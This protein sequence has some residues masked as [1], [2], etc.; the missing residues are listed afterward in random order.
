ML[1]RQS[2]L[3][4]TQQQVATGKRILSPSDDVYGSTQILALNK[5][6]DTHVQYEENADV[7]EARLNQEEISLTQNINVLQRA[8]ELAVQASN[9]TLSAADRGLIAAEVRDC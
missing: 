6:I 3:S 2:E 1:D 4:K 7:V 8:K 9:V 5:A